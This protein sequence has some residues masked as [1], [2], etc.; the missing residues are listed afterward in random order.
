MPSGFCKKLMPKTPEQARKLEKVRDQCWGLYRD[1]KL[2]TQKPSEKAAP[3]LAER[4][5]NIFR[6]RTDYKELG[7]FLARLH[8]EP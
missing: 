3:V 1:Q 5:D 6:Q 7:W 8:R 4:F 2:W